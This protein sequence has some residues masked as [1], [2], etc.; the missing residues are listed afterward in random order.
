MFAR[1]GMASLSMFAA[2]VVAAQDP[3][4]PAKGPPKD[5]AL[6][7]VIPG[8]ILKEDALDRGR[9]VP[10]KVHAVRLL[11]GKSY[12]IDHVSSDFD[13]YLRLEDSAGNTLAEDDDGG[14]MLNS[15]IRF[16]P[17]KDDVFL[18]YATS[19]G[20]GEGNYTLSVKSFV[21]AAVKLIPLPA[22]AAGKPGEVQGQLNANDPADQ[23]RNQPS[24]V[25]TVDLKANKK[26][27]IDLMSKQF[28]CY[29]ILQDANGGL[30][31]QN[32]DGGDGLN[33]RLQYQPK[34]DGRFRLVATTFNGQLGAFTLRVTEQP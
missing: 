26:Y 12:I 22:P 27:V 17:V 16:T 14:G 8:Q 9:N 19:L 2:A 29:L 28:D 5:D 4:P 11:K 34:A 13:A 10:G 15:R 23:F 25:H 24:K 31:A 7:L 33:S 21:A 3:A 6:N 20:G 30:I 32:D 18:I 1:L